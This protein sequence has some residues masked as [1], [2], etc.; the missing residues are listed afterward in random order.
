M[1][2]ISKDEPIVIILLGEF[3]VNQFSGKV[4]FTKDDNHPIGKFK[5]SWIKEGFTFITTDKNK[6]L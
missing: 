3:Y 4:I 6:Q 5:D 1:I 2:A